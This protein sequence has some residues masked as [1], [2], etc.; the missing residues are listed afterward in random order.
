MRNKEKDGDGRTQEGKNNDSEVVS[1]FFTNYP[2]GWKRYQ[3]WE[4]FKRHGTVVNVYIARKRNSHGKQFEFV[5]FIKV[6]DI[7]DF[8]KVLNTIWIGSHMLRV[9]VP[10]FQI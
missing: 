2:E 3:L 10:K 8:K 7:S 9:N 4:M 1:F 6:G 5:R